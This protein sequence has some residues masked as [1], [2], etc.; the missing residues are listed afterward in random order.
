MK[1]QTKKELKNWRRRRK[2]SEK[3]EDLQFLKRR[4]DSLEKFNFLRE[5]SNFSSR[6]Y[7]LLN[8]I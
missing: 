4:S 8:K 3:E 1:I 2:R 5:Y 6:T 7:S